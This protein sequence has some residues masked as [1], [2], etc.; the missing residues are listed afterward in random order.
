ML[1]TTTRY[2]NH[3]SGYLK[4]YAD[5]NV[6]LEMVTSDTQMVLL[7]NQDATK[8]EKCTQNKAVSHKRR[9]KFKAQA[10]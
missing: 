5:L 4:L 6:D 1:S 9:H 2:W 3:N 10:K 8:L 7:Q